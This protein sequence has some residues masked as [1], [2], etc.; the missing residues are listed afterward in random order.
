[1][2]NKLSYRTLILLLLL[3]LVVSLVFSL[4]VGRAQGAVL[5]LPLGQ[6]ELTKI[7]L[8]EIRLPRTLWALLIGFTLGLAGAS[9]QGLLRNPLVEP[10]IVGT[11]GSAALG[12]VLIIY[13]ASAIAS[14][15]LIAGAGIT[16]AFAGL[17]VLYLLAMK[18]ASIPTLIL[19]GVAV[20]AL[21]SAMIALALNLA[22]NPFAASEILIWLMGSVANRE[23][24]LIYWLIT[25][26]ALGW[27][28]MFIAR[29]GLD[30]LTLGEETASTLGVSVERTKVITIIGAGLAVG[31]AVSVAGAISFIGLVVPHLLRPLVHYRPGKLLLPSA[32]AG[33]IL[34]LLSDILVRVIPIQAELKLG[35]ITAL[36]GSP[37]FIYMLIQMQKDRA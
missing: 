3:L 7:I 10:G 25:P 34:L 6:G 2:T 17:A 13:F 37:F 15:L 30:A 26:L 28:L 21:T 14:P 1:M 32:L 9:L 11:S 27:L 4:F 22:P 24:S 31:T 36:L 12:A 29:R 19:A 23:L 18:Q 16:G 35:V 20:N 33:A 5:G 8:L